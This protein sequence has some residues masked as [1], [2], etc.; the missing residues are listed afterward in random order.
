MRGYAL[1]RAGVHVAHCVTVLRSRVV[2]SQNAS[3][4]QPAPTAVNN[5]EFPHFLRGTRSS[6]RVTDP[7]LLRVS[8]RLGEKQE[9]RNVGKM[10]LVPTH[11]LQSRK[12]SFLVAEMVTSR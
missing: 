4:K 10:Q 12:N 2:L 5:R 3:L 1:C 7:L 8:T 6:P 9:F 11:V